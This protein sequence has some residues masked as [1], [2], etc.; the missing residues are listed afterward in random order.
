M[1]HKFHQGPLEEYFGQLRQKGGCRQNPTVNDIRHQMNVMRV[2]NSASM[3]AVK[4]NV[5]PAVQNAAAVD[6]TPLMRRAR[7][8][9]ARRIP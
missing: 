8:A 5:T 6:V 4:G 9:V 1:S 3:T 7:P 2:I